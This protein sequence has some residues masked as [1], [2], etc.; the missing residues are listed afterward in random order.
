[1]IKFSRDEIFPGEFSRVGV[2]AKILFV[3]D[4]IMALELMGKSA[5]LL[6]YSPIL[7]DS[8]LG[9]L[10]ILKNY[11]PDIIFVD[12]SLN[13]IDGISLIKEMRL[14]N[15]L[16][17]VSIVMLSAGHGFIDAEKAVKAGADK[18]LQKPLSLDMLA[19]TIHAYV[20][21]QP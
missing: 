9:S 19:E 12:H 3:D 18:Y 1:M 5:S 4:D 13:D 14:L 21:V 15:H 11:S 10:E 7:C 8:G 20:R 6:G 2:M 16:N 17:D